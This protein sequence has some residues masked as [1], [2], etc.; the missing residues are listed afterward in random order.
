MSNKKPVSKRQEMRA[1]RRRRERRKRL[2][3][4]LAIVGVAVAL[5]ALLI[6]PG[7]RDALAPVTDV[8]IITP[9]PR[10]MAEGVAMGDPE[11]PVR[12]DVFAD[13]QCSACVTFARFTE[14]RIAEELVATG[15]VYYVF[16]QFPFLDD[17][18]P[19]NES[20]QA[21]NASMC[22]AEQGRFWDYHDMLYENLQGVNQGSFR[23]RRLI[24]MAEALELDMSAFNSCFDQNR[25][26]ESIQQDRADGERM[27][28]EGTP[29]VFVNDT[30]VEPGFVPTYEQVLEA[31][32]AAQAQSQ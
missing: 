23:D 28:V 29:A 12:I 17:F 22:A 24:A 5:V 7:I 21:A 1:E 15:E 4:V 14:H 19:G 26:S 2:V 32:Q 9:T 6:G 13:F 8:T 27:N 30:P 20:K 11:A 18:V 10:F 31:V 25:Y 16:R 3:F